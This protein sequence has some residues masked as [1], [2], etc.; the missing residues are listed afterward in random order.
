MD[1]IKEKL[2]NLLE[3][4]IGFEDITSKIL[5][6]VDAKGYIIA[7]E[8]C[9]ISCLEYGKFLFEYQ[10][11]KVNLLKKDGDFVK[12]GEKILEINGKIKDILS[13]ERTVLNVL[14]RAFGITTMTK[15]CTEKVNARVAATRKTLLRYLDKKAV[16][17]GGGDTHRYRLDDMILI[18]DNHISVMG[19]KECI[20]RAKKLSFSK[21]IEIEVTKKEDAIK[22]AEMGVDIIM[23]DNMSPEEIKDT[24]QILE[25]K[26]LRNN[27]LIEA[28]GGINLANIKKYDQVDIISLGFLTH[29]VAAIDIS[30]EII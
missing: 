23:L 9:Y 22:A 18:K 1:Y 4:D 3:E 10:N 29:S 21:K 8:D 11:C 15:K 27:V 7:K 24:I 19:L 5:P 20:K 14:C 13:T 16:E 28:S 2:I 26:K 12:K 6:D 17:I 25:T 30:L